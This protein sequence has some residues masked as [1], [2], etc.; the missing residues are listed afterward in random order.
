M[1]HRTPSKKEQVLYKTTGGKKGQKNDNVK[2]YKQNNL[3][4]GYKPHIIVDAE[5]EIPIAIEVLPVNT[6]DKK[7]FDQL[8]AKVKKIIVLQ[9]QFKFLADAQYDSANVKAIIRNNN[10]IPVIAINGR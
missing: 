1:G 6:N 5:T 3:F 10:G 2:R 4:Y 8:Y 7:L 9:Y